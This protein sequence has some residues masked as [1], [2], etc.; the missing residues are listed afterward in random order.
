MGMPLPKKGPSAGGLRI[1]AVIA[2]EMAGYHEAIR[3]QR[4]TG[5]RRIRPC[6]DAA[7]Q[8]TG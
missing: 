2:F 8:Q 7:Y 3:V 5:T 6:A 1:V 4:A